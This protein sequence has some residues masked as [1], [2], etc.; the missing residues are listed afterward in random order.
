MAVESA[1]RRL[2]LL[3]RAFK[4][5]GTVTDPAATSSGKLFH[6][7]ETGATALLDRLARNDTYLNLAG[8][9]MEQT[10]LVQA[11]GARSAETLLH[12]MRLPTAS[13]LSE[14]R[15]QVR[16]VGDQV[17]ALSLQIEFI[18]EQLEASQKTKGEG[19][20]EAL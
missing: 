11:E 9:M 13:D 17:E 12:A 6:R 16:K 7:L 19:G 20:G 15:D 3:A 8:R 18:L 4:L 10:F 14:V 2:N 1:P 5:I